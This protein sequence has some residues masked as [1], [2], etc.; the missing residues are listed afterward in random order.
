VTTVRNFE[1]LSDIFNEDKFYLSN[2]IS[3]DKDVPVIK[4]HV[5]K[6][7]PVLN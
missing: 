2:K 3:R 7:Y 4:H 6:M 5:M 1:V